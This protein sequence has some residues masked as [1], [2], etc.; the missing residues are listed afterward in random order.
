MTENGQD[1]KEPRV[2]QSDLARVTSPTLAAADLDQL[3]AGNNAFAFDLYQNLRD[4]GANLFFSP[5]ST[6]AALAMTYAGAR[7]RT[8]QQMADTLHLILPQQRL[9]SAFN[10]LDLQLMNSARD[11]FQLCIANALWGQIAYSF[12][13]EFLDLLAQNYGAALR[14]LDF[15]R[16]PEPSRQSINAWVSDETQSKI[17]DLIPPGGI[18]RET[19]LV[20]SNA[21]YFN[22]QWLMPFG[23]ALTHDGT[24]TTLNGERVTVRMMA[25]SEPAALAYAGGD[26]YQAVELPY[27]GDRMAML[28]LVPDMGEFDA[29]ESALDAERVQGILN[30]SEP[31]RVAL[32]VPKFRYS[33]TFGLAQTLARMGMPDAFGQAD[34]SGMDGTLK[35]FISDVFHKAFVAVDEAGTEA[36]AATAVLISRTAL[37]ILDVELTLD[38][39]FI[40]LIRD[41]ASGSILF[42]GRVV[43]PS[44]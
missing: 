4:K 34:F 33:S 5:Y 32:K 28:V 18:T 38:R 36:A 19:T 14:L 17:Q 2:L 8:E 30:A 27:Q 40:F 22:A 41:Q 31:K 37:P 10:A 25:R 21:I 26:G 1:A 13:P 39:P 12:L 15:A 42:L 20:L 16:Q 3:V 24:F 23:S 29:F 9:H 11:A 44:Q 43:N 6:S 35:L 7:G